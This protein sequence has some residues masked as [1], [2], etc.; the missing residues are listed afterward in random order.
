MAVA[1]LALLTAAGALLAACGAAEISDDVDTASQAIRGG[2]VDEFTS[3]VVGLGIHEVNRFYLGHCSGTLIAPN[4]VLTARHCVTLLSLDEH[5]NEVECGVTGFRLTRS[6]ESLIVSPETVRPDTPFDPS[7]VHAVEVH[8][9]PGADDVCGFDVALLV[10]E[11]PLG[12]DE[13]TPITPRIDEPA[14]TLEGFSAGGY[15]LTSDDEDATSGQ[16]MRIDGNEALCAPDE[17]YLQYPE[18]VTAAEWVSADAGVCSGDSGGPALDAEGRVIGVASRGGD[19]CR[20][21]VY[22]DVATWRDFIIEMGFHAAELGDYE[23]P[24]WTSGSS[25]PPDMPPGSHSAS[26]ASASPASEV[27]V[28]DEPAR[29][30]PSASSV[31]DPECAPTECSQGQSFAAE[32]GCSLRAPRRGGGS[33]FGLILVF[34]AVLARAGRSMT[35]AT[36]R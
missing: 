12:A 15:G 1:R 6:A 10:L 17:C 14:R 2:Y 22:G 26:P 24:H 20:A 34:C 7:F 30:E 25:E 19:D 16:R 11:R 35:R 28:L 21:T 27:V 33:Q 18:I 5:A 29:N 4:L 13:A 9:V 8:P 3:G 36:M 32:S 31:D 23:P